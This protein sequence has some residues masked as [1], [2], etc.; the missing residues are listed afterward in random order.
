MGCDWV[1]WRWD[2]GLRSN[3]FV[4]E[5]VTAQR[6]MVLKFWCFHVSAVLKISVGTLPNCSKYDFLI[7]IYCLYLRT[8]CFRQK[9]WSRRTDY[10]ALKRAN[11]VDHVLQD[12]DSFRRGNGPWRRARQQ[13]KL[14]SGSAFMCF[15]AL[16]LEFKKSKRTEQELA[17]DSDLMS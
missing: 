16:V 5:G 10:R 11:E 15:V 4:C 7:S 17:L 9:S 2:L 12:T 14:C 1:V 3:D 8:L 6:W 13:R